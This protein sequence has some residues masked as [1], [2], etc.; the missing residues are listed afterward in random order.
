MS[1]VK[2]LAILGGTFD[3][4][5]LGHLQI[6]ERVMQA[7][8]FTELSF[9]PCRLPVL[10]GPPACSDEDRLAMLELA[11][12]AHPQ[13]TINLC[14]LSRPGPSYMVDS[15]HLLRTQRPD[16]HLILIIG[17]DAFVDLPRWHRW[18]H[19][20]D[21]ANL[22][23]LDRPNYDRFFSAELAALVEAHQV[24]DKKAWL[25]RPQGGLY[26]YNAG[27]YPISSTRIREAIRHGDNLQAD[28]PAEVIAYIK[29]HQLYPGLDSQDRD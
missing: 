2:T 22:L 29:T 14:E 4:V 12:A 21:E 23:V 18:Q 24:M 10:K 17:M 19:L 13:W 27:L 8:H 1:T 25:Q 5:H 11:L 7:F 16:W 26:F 15:L 20:L 3:P 28:I 9:M 6:A